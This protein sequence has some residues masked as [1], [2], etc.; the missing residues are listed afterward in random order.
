MREDDE[1]TIFASLHCGKRVKPDNI[2]NAIIERREYLQ[3]IDAGL[4]IL[5]SKG[6]DIEA[7]APLVDL[8]M[9]VQSDDGSTTALSDKLAEAIARWEI[10]LRNL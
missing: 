10:A 9:Q 3:M 7:G 5:K 2:P 1:G 6:F 8:K 4:L